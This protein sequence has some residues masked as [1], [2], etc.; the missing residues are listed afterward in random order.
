MDLVIDHAVALFAQ[1]GSAGSSLSGLL[2]SNYN[3]EPLDHLDCLPQD[4]GLGGSSIIATIERNALQ[5]CSRSDHLALNA[6]RQTASDPT[7]GSLEAPKGS[8]YRSTRYAP[9]SPCTG[10]DWEQIAGADWEQIVHRLWKTANS[11]HRKLADFRV[12]RLRQAADTDYLVP[13]L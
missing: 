9:W 12:F 3:K 4:R 2:N 5:A 8:G 6:A 10:A 7:G 13:G 1:A 11:I